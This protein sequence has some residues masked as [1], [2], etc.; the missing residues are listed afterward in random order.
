[1]PRHPYRMK[2]WESFRY[3]ASALRAYVERKPL[4][5][6]A[7][8]DWPLAIELASQQL[9][10]TAV[11]LALTRQPEVPDDVKEYFAAVIELNRDRNAILEDAICLIIGALNRHGIEPLLLKG[12]A[13]LLEGLYPHPAARLIADIDI[14]VPAEAVAEAS[15]ILSAEGYSNAVLPPSRWI[16]DLADHH[17]PMQAS[18]EGLAGV[19]LHHELVRL[20]HAHL[21]K[22]KD[23]LARALTRE[24]GELRYLIL[25][26]DDCVMH[27]IIHAQ[28]QHGLHEKGLADLRQMADLALLID[29]YGGAINWPEISSRFAAAGA[30]AVLDNQLALLQELFGCR[31]PVMFQDS[32]AALTRL[33]RAVLGSPVR[34]ARE[35]AAEYWAGFRARP[36]RAINLLNPTWWPKRIRD[37]RARARR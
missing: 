20:G 5:P 2:R 30:S 7:E 35:I 23:A 13:H 37:W 11:G 8:P 36:L 22:A 33:R 6:T 1:M 17:L 25:C 26:P 12:A 28:I 10:A 32:A 4:G 16:S 3:I 14:L 27:N 21:I 9:V 29:K 24:R 18:E 15:Q 34:V 19:E 31:L